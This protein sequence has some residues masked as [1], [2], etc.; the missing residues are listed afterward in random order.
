MIPEIEPVT[1]CALTG[2]LTSSAAKHAI[3]MAGH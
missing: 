2:V 3:K 1:D